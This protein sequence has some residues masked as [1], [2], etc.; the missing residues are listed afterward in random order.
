MEVTGRFC[1]YSLPSLQRKVFARL[2]QKI[3]GKYL[4]VCK[5]SNHSVTATL[6]EA[7]AGLLFEA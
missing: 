1:F 6:E 2:N 7:M 4:H 3:R 5:A